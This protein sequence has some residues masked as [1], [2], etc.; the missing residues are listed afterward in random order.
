MKTNITVNLE[1][2]NTV[3]ID[4]LS[5]L[6]ALRTEASKKYNFKEADIFDDLICNQIGVQNNFHKI[7]VIK[8]KKAI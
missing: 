2:G 5:V 7:K 6:Q 3:E 4:R 1:N 8:L